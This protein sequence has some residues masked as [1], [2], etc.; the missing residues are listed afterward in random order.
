MKGDRADI[1]GHLCGNIFGQLEMDRARS[2]LHSD[3]EGVAHHGRNAGRADDLAR[4]FGQRTHRGNYVDDLE[5]R[6]LSGSDR[7][8]AGDHDHWHGTEVGISGAGRE[9]EGARAECGYTY[10]GTAGKAPMRCS[11][12]RC[13]L[14]MTCQHQFDFRTPQRLDNIKVFLTRNAENAVD[15]LVFERRDKKVRAFM[16]MSPSC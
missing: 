10:A 1:F 8:L 14:L 6:L 4:H 7:L 13:R 3:S 15:A 5:T 11:H 16:H 9:I 12:K 2:L